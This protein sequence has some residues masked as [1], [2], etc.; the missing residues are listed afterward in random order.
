MSLVDDS[1]I[2]ILEDKLGTKWLKLLIVLTHAG[3][4]LLNHVLRYI[5]FSVIISLKAF[6]LALINKAKGENDSLLTVAFGQIGVSSC[7]S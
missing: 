2:N 1:N 7:N 3:R 5:L 6:G 4:K